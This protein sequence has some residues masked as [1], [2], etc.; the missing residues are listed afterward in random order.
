MHGIHALSVDD[1]EEKGALK[2]VS[3]LE[4]QVLQFLVVT[5]VYLVSR[6]TI[7]HQ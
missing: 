4:D 7:C 2:S 5:L 6:I 3:F 1:N